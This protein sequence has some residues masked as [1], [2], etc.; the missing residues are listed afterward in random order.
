[1]QRSF[2][3]KANTLPQARCTSNIL[4]RVCVCAL[5]PISSVGSQGACPSLF[6]Q[7]LPSLQRSS[8]LSTLGASKHAPAHK[9][10]TDCA[11]LHGGVHDHL[12]TNIVWCRLCISGHTLVVDGSAW[13]W[14]K[15]AANP[16]P[17][18]LEFC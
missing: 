1:M 6:N 4:R 18:L 9:M 14:C 11:G 7:S 2:L 15:P 10:T 13:M 8:A 5:P 16:P 3:D 12:T 17:Y